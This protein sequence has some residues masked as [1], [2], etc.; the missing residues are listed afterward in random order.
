MHARAIS[1]GP[2][3]NPHA[4]PLVT[5]CIATIPV[6]VWLYPDG[7]DAATTIITLTGHRGVGRLRPLEARH[8]C[9]L[10]SLSLRSSHWAV[11]RLM[12]VL[13]GHQYVLERRLCVLHRWF[14]RLVFF[15]DGANWLP[16][17]VSSV[18]GSLDTT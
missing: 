6:G 4:L 10:C 12:G 7:A 8:R 18:Y 14:L 9:W 17:E 16:L 13:R 3:N 15:S 11:L 1:K 5:C 2:I